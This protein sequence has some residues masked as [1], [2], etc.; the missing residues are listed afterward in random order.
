METLEQV[1]QQ[2]RTAPMSLGQIKPIPDED[3]LWW[4]CEDRRKGHNLSD[5]ELMDIAYKQVGEPLGYGDWI[6]GC[7]SPYDEDEVRWHGLFM[8]AINPGCYDEILAYAANND[9]NFSIKFCSDHS[10]AVTTG[11]FASTKETSD[12]SLI[13]WEDLSCVKPGLYLAAQMNA[14]A[15]PQKSIFK[16]VAER[17]VEQLSISG[18]V[19]KHRW[20]ITEHGYLK[21]VIE[22]C[23]M[24]EVSAVYNSA[25]HTCIARAITDGRMIIDK[26]AET[27]PTIQKNAQS[28]KDCSCQTDQNTKNMLTW[29]AEVDKKLADQPPVTIQKDAEPEGEAVKLDTAEKLLDGIVTRL[30][31]LLGTPEEETPEDTSPEPAVAPALE[32]ETPPAVAPAPETETPPDAEET[33]PAV[34]LMQNAE[35]FVA[36]PIGD[37][38]I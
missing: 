8:D 27:M 16:Q 30:E 21:R 33:E 25:F 18:L 14:T 13:V 28:G 35:G 11:I 23:R 9:Q 20:D 29:M 15:D 5:Q 37:I 10:C 24:L 7:A 19:T 1:L 26:G 6:I 34:G 22:A 32:T 31:K 36:V 4:R 12:N 2:I 38:E 17:T 3:V